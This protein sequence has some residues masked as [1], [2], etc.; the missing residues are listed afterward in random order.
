LGHLHCGDKGG[1]AEREGEE[2]LFHGAI[3]DEVRAL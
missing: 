1:E 3:R 2:L